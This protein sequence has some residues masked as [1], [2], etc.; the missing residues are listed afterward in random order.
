MGPAPA[1]GPNDRIKDNGHKQ[2][3]KKF[4]LNTRKNHFEGA[5][6]QPREDAESPSQDIQ[7]PPGHEPVQ[8]PLNEPALAQ[9]FNK[10]ISRGCF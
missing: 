8:P 3:G 7:N 9:G 6:E 4:Y 10:M 5:L 1:V 2:K